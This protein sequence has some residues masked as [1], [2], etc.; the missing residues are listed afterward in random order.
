MN[1]SIWIDVFVCPSC[2]TEL[3]LWDV[4]VDEDSKTIKDEFNCPH[5]GNLCSKKTMKKAWETVFDSI[6]DDTISINKKVPVKFC[7]S[8][9]G[10]RGEKVLTKVIIRISKR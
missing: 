1:S 7:Y 2:N 6:L 3:V 9:N 4:A 8:F 10:R 5:C